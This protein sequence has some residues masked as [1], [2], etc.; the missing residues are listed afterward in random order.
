MAI[1]K[2]IAVVVW[3]IV[4]MTMVTG[5]IRIMTMVTIS[6]RGGD[7]DHRDRWERPDQRQAKEGAI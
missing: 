4:V 7:A 5:M 1:G 6:R 2:V 3:L